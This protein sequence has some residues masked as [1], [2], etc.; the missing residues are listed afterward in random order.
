M[1]VR[2]EGFHRCGSRLPYSLRRAFELLDAAPRQ[3]TKSPAEPDSPFPSRAVIA[4]QGSHYQLQFHAAEPEIYED[5]ARPAQC[6]EYCDSRRR[7]LQ[8]AGLL[9]RE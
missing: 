6:T 1:E 9:Q 8:H 3:M 7:Q 4:G 2:C 5:R